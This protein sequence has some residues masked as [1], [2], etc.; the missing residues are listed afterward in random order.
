M[1]W[2]IEDKQRQLGHQYQKQ[3]FKMQERSLEFSDSMFWKQ[4]GIQEEQVG[5]TRKWAQEDWDYQG[6]MRSMQWQWK[7]EDFQENI[8]YASGRERRLG[9]RQMQRETTMFNAEGDQIEKQK[10]RQEEMWK[11]EDERFVLEKE[12][13]L[14]SMTMQRKQLVMQK[15]YY[16]ERYELESKQIKLQ[17]EYWKEQIELQKRSAGVSAAAAKASSE[18]ADT[19]LMIAQGFEENMKSGGVYD[20]QVWEEL[21]TLMGLVHLS[22]QDFKKDLIEVKKLIDAIVAGGGSNAVGGYY[23]PGNMMA[24]FGAE[25]LVAE[26]S[27]MRV[28]PTFVHNPW[29]DALVANTKNQGG[30]SPSSPTTVIINVGGERLKEFVIDTISKEVSV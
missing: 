10:S 3:Q 9:E 1:F 22:F 6:A 8:R 15:E 25:T 11:L 26:G 24:E 13:H 17:R 12:Q 4:R 18:Y 23:S 21:G 14:E 29:Q 2:A 20:P 16:F 19:Q 5:L 30:G 27:R 7:Q 28:E